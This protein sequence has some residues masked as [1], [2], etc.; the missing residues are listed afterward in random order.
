M[1]TLKVIGALAALVT[2]AVHAWEW[3]F[4]GYGDPS[5]VS[6]VVGTAFLVNAVAGVVIAILL[7]VWRHWLP[8]FLLLGLGALTFGGFVTA[9]TVGLFGVHET[10][11][12]LPVWAAAVAE[13]VA[14]VVPFVYWAL[15]SRT[16]ERPGGGRG[17]GR[18]AGS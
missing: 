16:V 1:R 10:W 6:P 2:A 4:N 18:T 8:M 9:A 3:F 13:V 5:E 17:Q 11:T 15:A 7:L 14:I 12:G